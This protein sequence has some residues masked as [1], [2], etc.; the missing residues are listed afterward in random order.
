MWPAYSKLALALNPNLAVRLTTRKQ[1]LDFVLSSHVC[2]HKQMT[3]AST[4][5]LLRDE[6]GDMIDTLLEYLQNDTIR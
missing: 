3:L 4:A 2:S 1:R 5:L 6:R